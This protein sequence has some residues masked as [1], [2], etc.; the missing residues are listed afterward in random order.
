ME[1][2]FFFEVFKVALLV[3]RNLRHVFK[4]SSDFN[5]AKLDRGVQV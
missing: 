1:P 4:E 5:T 3:K 2:N